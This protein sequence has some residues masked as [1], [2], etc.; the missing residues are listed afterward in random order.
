[1][2]RLTDLI[3]G[4][5]DAAAAVRLG[6]NRARVAKGERPLA[7]DHLPFNRRDRALG[8]HEI[9]RVLTALE[10]QGVG[11]STRYRVRVLLSDAR[12]EPDPS[13]KEAFMLMFNA[14]YE[15]AHEM[16]FEQI[17][18]SPRAAWHVYTDICHACP[19]LSAES[20]VR[21]RELARR[22]R[23]HED[24][25]SRHTKALERIGLLQ[26]EQDGRGVRYVVL[27]VEELGLPLWNGDKASWRDAISEARDRLQRELM[28]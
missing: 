16:I 18:R 4:T 8:A 20:A 10:A 26:S 11:D 19:R 5:S 22:T 13:R 6:I 28:V 27:P 2:K 1:M 12:Q 7:R 24:E 15:R 25:V 17:K 21:R 14:A 9:G 3:G 23:L